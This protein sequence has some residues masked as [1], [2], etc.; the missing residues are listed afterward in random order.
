[1]IGFCSLLDFVNQVDEQNE[2][3]GKKFYLKPNEM[4][5]SIY[6]KKCTNGIRF[7]FA[8]S[9]GS[10]K[11]LIYLWPELLLDIGRN[12][13]NMKYIYRYE[14]IHIS[15]HIIIESESILVITI[16]APDEWMSII[17]I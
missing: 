2:K 15:V 9:S 17:I 1:M 6:L 13:I 5:L 8:D 14:S 4:W 10:N 12:C 16:K 7:Q 11:T 3:N